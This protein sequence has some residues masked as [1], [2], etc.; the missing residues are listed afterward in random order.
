MMRCGQGVKQSLRIQECKHAEEVER[1]ALLRIS[2]TP[3]NYDD[4]LVANGKWRS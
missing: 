3:E 2:S 4:Q 1:Q